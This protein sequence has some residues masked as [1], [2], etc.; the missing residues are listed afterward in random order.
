M[1]RRLWYRVFGYGKCWNCS[2]ALKGLRCEWCGYTL[3]GYVSP[4]SGDDE[5]LHCEPCGNH[6]H[7]SEGWSCKKC[8]R[9][10]A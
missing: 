3:K 5:N 2:R 8:G 1:F 9:S 10:G 6:W 4:Y 7:Y